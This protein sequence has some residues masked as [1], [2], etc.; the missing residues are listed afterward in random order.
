MQPVEMLVCESRG[1]ARERYIVEQGIPVLPVS[2][3]EVSN[4]TVFD[5][6]G[7]AVNAN[8]QVEGTDPHGMVRWVLVSL[9][10]DVEAG[11]TRR[12]FLKSGE[13]KAVGDTLDVDTG[14]DG[15]IVVQNGFFKL[16]MTDPGDIRL[17]TDNGTLLDGTV[18]FDIKSD[19]R[20]SV[21]NQRPVCYE[22]EGFKVLEQT[23]KRIR[24]LLKG[25]YKAWAPKQFF[26]DPV[27]RYDADVEFT[28]HAGSPVI[29][30]KW[31]ITNYM[32]FNHPYMW[33][34]RYVLSFPLTGGS[35]ASDGEQVP[36]EDKFARWA[37]ASTPG[38][39]LAMTFPFYEWL[40]RGGGIEIKDGRIGQGGINPPVDGGFG[41]KYPDIHRKFFHGMSRTF[42]GSLLVD[43]SENQIKSEYS[44]IPMILSPEHYSATGQLPEKGSSVTF[45]P[46][47]D[48]VHRAADYLLET[49]WKG[50]LWFGEWWR[51]RDIDEDLG[52]EETNSGNS[53][54]TPCALT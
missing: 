48:V 39:T 3:D 20:S 34:K 10:V 19:A 35:I 11:G 36:G 27:Q 16:E 33:L 28:I 26:F 9:P 23:P 32:R 31:T 42:E 53:A 50:T 41:G 8:V 43:P 47:K 54:L 17:S 52:I 21:G 49:Q 7:A 22:P 25:R 13:S 29:R 18:G 5:E 44:H 51:E 14:T 12:F 40:G 4:L 6:S 24:I 38:G 45:G 1:V 15:S 46:W 30:F 2:L 37:S